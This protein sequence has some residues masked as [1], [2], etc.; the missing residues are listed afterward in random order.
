MTETADAN[1]RLIES[2]FEAWKAGTGNIADLFAPTMVWRIEGLSL[3][4]G[5][6]TSAR[7][8]ID[9]VLQ[10]FAARFSTGQRFRPVNIRSVLADG[11]TV[12]VVWDGHGVANDGVPYDNSYAWIL[13]LRDGKVIDG[14]AFFDSIAFDAFWRR[15]TP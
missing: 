10:P 4:C 2:A 3:V 1:R 14:T 15:V 12:V 8:F 7:D 5:E 6:Y 11:D 13:Q 9:G